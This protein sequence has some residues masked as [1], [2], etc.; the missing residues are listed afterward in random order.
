M[1]MSTLCMRYEIV[2]LSRRF[3]FGLLVVVALSACAVS[4]ARTGDPPHEGHPKVKT[5][6]VGTTNSDL[7]E[8]EFLIS[9]ENQQWKRRGPIPVKLR[10]HNAGKVPITGICSF[11]LDDPTAGNDPYKEGR[12]LWAPVIFDEAGVQPARVIPG[13]SASSTLD[14]GQTLELQVD[15]NKLNWGKVIQNSWPDGTF[16]QNAEP[17]N[18]EFSFRM[19]VRTGET[20]EQIESNKVK[21]SLK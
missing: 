16:Y 14:P 7:P 12:N 10:L 1:D 5:Q 4:L 13:E 6:N 15:L 20:R 9:V 18:F 21:V 11:Q 19:N 2:R 3:I 17:G 8:L